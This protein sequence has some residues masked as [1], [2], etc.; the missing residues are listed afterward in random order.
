MENITLANNEVFIGQL[1]LELVSMAA[2]EA[3]EQWNRF[4]F[5]SM[6]YNK[7]DN[8]GVYL[9]RSPQNLENPDGGTGYQWK[10]ESSEANREIRSQALELANRAYDSSFAFAD[11]WFLLQTNDSWIDNPLHQHMTSDKQVVIYLQTNEEDYLEFGDLADPSS[12]ERHKVSDGMVVIFN[13][14]AWHRP[15]P[16][17]GDINRISLNNGLIIKEIS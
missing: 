6:N 13:G 15:V 10:I 14:D 5:L 1:D 16:N 4:K 11:S 12:L 9:F 7:E 17:S 3:E 2:K 8:T